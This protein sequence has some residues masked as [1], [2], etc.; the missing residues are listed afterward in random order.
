MSLPVGPPTLG[1]PADSPTSELLAPP[2]AQQV[3]W[4]Q[5]LGDVQGAGLRASVP[6]AGLPKPSATCRQTCSA[7][8]LGQGLGEGRS[9]GRS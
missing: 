7:R 3:G 5:R 6:L 8:G 1:F 2:Q 4:H 9:G